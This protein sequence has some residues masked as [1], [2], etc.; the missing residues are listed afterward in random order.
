M[1]VAAEEGLGTAARVEVVEGVAETSSG[2]IHVAGTLEG[3]QT[4]LGD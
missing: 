1:G 2:E 3:D 4:T